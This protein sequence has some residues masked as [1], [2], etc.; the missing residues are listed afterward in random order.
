MTILISNDVT[1][2]IKYHENNIL[3]R[4]KI[5]FENTKIV[6]WQLLMCNQFIMSSI[7]FPFMLKICLDRQ[8]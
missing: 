8:L 1:I 7:S 3:S 5:D 6:L 2:C 4:A